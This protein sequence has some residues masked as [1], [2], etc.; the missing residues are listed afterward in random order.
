[1]CQDAF[2][3]RLRPVHQ[4]YRALSSRLSSTRGDFR[5]YMYRHQEAALQHLPAGA[6]FWEMASLRIVHGMS[7][8][9]SRSQ[10]KIA[11]DLHAHD[12]S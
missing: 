5:W 8:V 6:V 4:G 9:Q 12:C 10:M 2:T 11:P 3:C 1:M 7:S